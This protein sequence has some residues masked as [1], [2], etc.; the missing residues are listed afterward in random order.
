MELDRI[1][2]NRMESNDMELERIEWNRMESNDME[3]DRIER[4][5]IDRIARNW[6]EFNKME[7]PLSNSTH[8]LIN[9]YYVKTP[10]SQVTTNP[11]YHCSFESLQWLSSKV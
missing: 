4:N 9:V 8:G 11:M 6:I 2:W 5:W 10:F 1:E 3:L 7:R